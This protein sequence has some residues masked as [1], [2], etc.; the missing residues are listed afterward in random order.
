MG[1]ITLK[2][3]DFQKS[4][5][6]LM[7]VLKAAQ[8]RGSVTVGVHEKEGLVKPPKSDMTVAEYAAANHFGTKRIPARPF[9]DVGVESVKDKIERD[10]KECYAKKLPLAQI[11]ARMGEIGAGGVRDYITNLKTPPNALSTQRKKGAKKG[12]GILIDNPLVDNG[13]L[14]ASITKEVHL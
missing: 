3:V 2:L 10:V 14:K 4:R 1:L 5:F 12:K 8:P 13:I 11:Y 6:A 7:K 9:L